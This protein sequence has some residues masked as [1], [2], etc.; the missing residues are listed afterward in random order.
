MSGVSIPVGEIRSSSNALAN[1]E[2]SS[3]AARLW[4]DLTYSMVKSEGCTV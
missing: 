1:M 4:T 2:V 3:T